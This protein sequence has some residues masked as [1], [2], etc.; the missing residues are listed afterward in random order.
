MCIK[1]VIQ[2]KTLLDIP[3]ALNEP[4]SIFTKVEAETSFLRVTEFYED[5]QAWRWERSWRGKV[6]TPLMMNWVD[7]L[8]LI[9][10]LQVFCL[11]ILIQN[12][13]ITVQNPKALAQ[14]LLNYFL[15][16]PLRSGNTDIFK[17]QEDTVR[18]LGKEL[19]TP[20]TGKLGRGYKY[21]S[22]ISNHSQ[23][24]SAFLPPEYS[25]IFVHAC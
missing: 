9:R 23:V 25:K 24:W 4:W 19:P 14:I 20:G 8:F 3:T 21:R 17:G 18:F 5:R 12:D 6:V 1:K 16:Q 22:L 11:V 2:C 15:M 10:P 7:P 13:T